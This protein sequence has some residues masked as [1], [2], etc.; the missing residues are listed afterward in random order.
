[1]AAFWPGFGR[2][3]RQPAQDG[4]HFSRL[5]GDLLSMAR[6]SAAFLLDD[7]GSCFGISS[8]DK[9]SR[10]KCIP[11]FRMPT[12]QPTNVLAI[13]LKRHDLQVALLVQFGVVAC[14][15][16]SGSIGHGIL[17]L[18]VLKFGNEARCSL[19][20]TTMTRYICISSVLGAFD[21]WSLLCSILSGNID[22]LF[23]CSRQVALSSIQMFFGPAAEILGASAAWGTFVQPSMLLVNNPPICEPFVLRS[24][25]HQHSFNGGY[26]NAIT[27]NVFRDEYSWANEAA[28]DGNH[29]EPLATVGE[30]SRYRC[31]E[32][33]RVVSSERT[34][35]GKGEFCGKLYCSDC[36]TNWQLKA[37]R[38]G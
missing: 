30:G 8:N 37:C 7:P 9:D 10:C 6:E 12:Y 11:P 23:N 34:R 25:G 17:G 31:D 29:S 27:N 36:W 21:A 32:C 22:V 15:I 2:A 19:A 28:S 3:G 14:R 16:L 5:L 38:A 33:H 13:E 35:T 20:S 4:D 1:M 18:I 24:S 26:Q